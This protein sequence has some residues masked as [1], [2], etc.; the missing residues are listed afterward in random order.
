MRK[1][2][3]PFGAG[4]CG[5]W[6]SPRSLLEELYGDF[7]WPGTPASAARNHGPAVKSNKK[8]KKSR[9]PA[10]SFVCFLGGLAFA[11]PFLQRPARTFGKILCTSIVLAP[12]LHH[13]GPMGF[14]FQEDLH[15]RSFQ[16]SPAALFVLSLHSALVRSCSS[17]FTF[18]QSSEPPVRTPHQ[19]VPMALP[20]DAQCD[21]TAARQLQ[22]CSRNAAALLQGY[23]G[24]A[25]VLHKGCGRAA[26]DASQGHH[27]QAPAAPL[28]IICAPFHEAG[29]GL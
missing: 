5:L 14:S 18:L 17:H 16:L 28:L 1:A 12:A 15:S 4:A 11:L 9:F 2:A 23:N 6:N 25:A 13:F 26:A 20:R 19:N 24:A 10:F 29:F 8:K 27:K 21:R 3:E 7:W 22:G